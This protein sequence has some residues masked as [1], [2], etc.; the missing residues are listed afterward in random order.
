MSNA[1]SRIK[2]ET[3]TNHWELMCEI[4]CNTGK[5]TNKRHKAIRTGAMVQARD[6]AADKLFV[7]A[8]KTTGVYCRPSRPTRL[9]RPENVEFFDIPAAA[10]AA[11]Y[12]AWKYWP[13]KPASARTIFIAYSMP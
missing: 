7:Y 5:P 11:G 10:E 9:P 1:A 2:V 3:K 13:P 4:S 6:P 8:V 12:R